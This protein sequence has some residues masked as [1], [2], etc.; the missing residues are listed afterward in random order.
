MYEKTVEKESLI[1]R[2]RNRC[3]VWRADMDGWSKRLEY[4]SCTL[5][6]SAKRRIRME[7][8]G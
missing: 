6:S 8:D 1:T 3:P 7:S 5:F 2:A 4:L